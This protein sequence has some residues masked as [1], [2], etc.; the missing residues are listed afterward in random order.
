MRMQ[1]RLVPPFWERMRNTLGG[2]FE[3]EQGGSDGTE[4]PMRS[5]ERVNGAIRAHL[6]ERPQERLTRVVGFIG[7]LPRRIGL[8]D[9][10]ARE[11][12]RPWAL[13]SP[14]LD[15]LYGRNIVSPFPVP[16]HLQQYPLETWAH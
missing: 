9:D 8:L 11:G 14:F 7:P 13:P 4:N 5:I 10:E 6:Q 3:R 12:R 1:T 16:T 15:P 2:P